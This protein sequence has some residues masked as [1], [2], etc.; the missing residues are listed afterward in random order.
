MWFIGLPRK[1]LCKILETVG[2][3]GNTIVA[4]G[5][6]EDSMT[7]YQVR[8]RTGATRV[9]ELAYLRDIKKER[10]REDEANRLKNIV[11]DYSI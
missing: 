9:Y 10:R 11:E 8:D 2:N 7:Y 5:L 1:Y 6:G 3:A 4:Y